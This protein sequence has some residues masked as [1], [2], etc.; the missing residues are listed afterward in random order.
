MSEQP[1]TQATLLQRPNINDKELWKAYWEKQDQPWRT[2]PEIDTE[3]QKYLSQR[4]AITPDIAQGIYPF[5]GIKLNRADIE[6]LLATHE[7]G[8]GP[9]EWN[10]ESP[11]RGEGIDLRGSDL[12][13]VNLHDLPLSCIRAGLS[14]SEASSTTLQQRNM[15]LVHL[16]DA[17]LSFAHLEGA[18][19]RNARL[20]GTYLRGTHLEGANLF[21]AHLEGAYLRETHLEGASLRSAFFD[22]GTNLQQVVLGQ[23]KLGVAL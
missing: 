5:Q 16:Q 8:C 3:R 1:N 14:R 17:D 12:R 13:G 21:G 18:Y 22:S 2:E 15:A 11:R 6:W 7:N 19:L 20:E 10:F 23:E 4:R 9:I